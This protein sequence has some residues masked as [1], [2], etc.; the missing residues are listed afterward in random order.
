MM[1][2]KER[3]ISLTDYTSLTGEESDFRVR[4]MAKEA[5]G[6]L[7]SVASVCVYPRFVSL[8]KDAF[9]HAKLPVLPVTSVVNFPDGELPLDE[10]IAE[11][12]YALQQGADE[13]D[14]VIPHSSHSTYSDF[15]A[16]LD[17][18]QA[19]RNEMHGKVLKLIIESGR[20]SPDEILRASE[21][22]IAAEVDFLKTSTGKVGGG[23][24][25]EAAEIML[26]C[27]RDSG[28]P[29]GF[30][31]SGGIRSQAD[32]EVYMA[33]AEKILGKD[34]VR[35]KTFRIGSGSL[36]KVLSEVDEK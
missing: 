4:R 28:R 5:H 7:G 34:F 2:T 9:V 1:D 27:I 10:V 3:I 18:V 29:C 12:H 30:K 17:F 32:A 15:D 26:S 36:L 31:A 20:L 13:I 19:C 24:T 33:L 23:A 22:G 11:I 21:V 14:L 8:V 6:P 25:P 16:K 35:P